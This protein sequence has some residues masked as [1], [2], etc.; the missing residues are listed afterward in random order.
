MRSVKV[1][2]GFLLTAF[3]L[4]S[5]AADP[6]IAS[7][8]FSPDG[9]T[10]VACSQAGVS[11]LDWPS[12]KLRRVFHAT[13]P[14]LHAAAFSPQGDVLAVAGGTPSEEGTVELF[15]WPSGESQKV[16]SHHRDSVMSIAWLSETQLTTASLD[17]DVA[18][19]DVPSGTIVHRMNGHSRGVRAIVALSGSDQ[20]VSAGIDQSL[21]LWKNSAGKLVHGMNIHTAPVSHL[22]VRPGTQA[23]PMVASSSEDRT[24]RFWQPT[25]G[26]MV[27]F[28][29]LPAVPL[30]VTW[31]GSGSEIVAGC[32]DGHLRMIDPES[33]EVVAD[34]AV[35]DTWINAVCV[36]PVGLSGGKSDSQTVAVGDANGNVQRIV[37]DGRSV[38]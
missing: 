2:I 28:A 18:I 36:S 10:L 37:L 29:R 11:L 31:I 30:G 25:I 16:V 32:T 8:T 6:P 5:A 17:N 9:K 12:L 7:L 20:L 34:I 14:N 1:L 4:T 21:R 13:S 33:A 26:R 35:S 27:R 15:S 22:S 19:Y 3:T 23:L 38:Q 24:I